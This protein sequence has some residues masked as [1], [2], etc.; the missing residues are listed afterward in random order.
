MTTRK[1]TFWDVIFPIDPLIQL[2]ES[3]QGFVDSDQLNNA[4]NSSM[5]GAGPDPVVG[6]NKN[7]EDQNDNSMLIAG[8]VLVVLVAAGVFVYFKFKK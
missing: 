5:S 6:L 4:F 3:L 1:T 8:I 2:N 7:A